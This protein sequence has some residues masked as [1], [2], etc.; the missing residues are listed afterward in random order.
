MPAPSAQSTARVEGK[1]SCAIAI[2]T[3]ATT[4]PETSIVNSTASAEWRLAFSP[5]KKSAEPQAVEAASANT[6]PTPGSCQAGST[7][8]TTAC[9]APAATGPAIGSGRS[10]CAT[11]VPVS[12]IGCEAGGEEGEVGGGAGAGGVGF[13]CR[14]AGR[15]SGSVL[16]GG[17][18]ANGA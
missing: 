8:L 17:R 16:T 4:R 13:G 18:L 15:R 12:W 9:T 2:T 1:G 7:R 10:V 3:A 11:W 14:C 5:P 6:M